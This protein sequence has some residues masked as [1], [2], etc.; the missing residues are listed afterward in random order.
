MGVFPTWPITRRDREVAPDRSTYVQQK[1]VGLVNGAVGTHEIG[2][3]G[4][5]LSLP[6][7][8]SVCPRTPALFVLVGW[9][10]YCGT[11]VG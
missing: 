7:S 4:I 11:A 1:G 6:L 10:V 3:H 9:F 2:T 8:P 5:V